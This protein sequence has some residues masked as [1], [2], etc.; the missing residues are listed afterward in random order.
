[1]NGLIMRRLL[2]VTLLPK[3][4]KLFRLDPAGFAAFEAW[5]GPPTLDDLRKS[6]KRRFAWSFTLGVL[7][8]LT[9]L[10]LPGDP[11]RDIPDLPLNSLSLALGIGL[12]A[13]GLL[14]RFVP[15]R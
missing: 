13:A 2:G 14:S 9:S 7:I 10:P 4:K 6:L 5:A 12:I 8:I 1:M 15:S 11:E 3:G